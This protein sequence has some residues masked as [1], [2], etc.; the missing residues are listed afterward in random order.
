MVMA[1][2]WPAM[3]HAA[4][5]RPQPALPG[6]VHAS[7]QSIQSSGGSAEGDGAKWR[8]LATPAVTASQSHHV[9]NKRQRAVLRQQITDQAVRESVAPTGSR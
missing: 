5:A 8:S 3:A 6:A 7:A 1:L 9:L 4:S 2:A